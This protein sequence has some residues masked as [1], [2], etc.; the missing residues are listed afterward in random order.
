MS[1]SVRSRIEEFE[2][3]SR[4][5]TEERGDN[6]KERRNEATTE[7]REASMHH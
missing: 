5:S 1:K 2:A 3:F 4:R 7:K 6:S